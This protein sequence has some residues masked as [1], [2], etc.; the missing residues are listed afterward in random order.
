MIFSFINM[1]L[2]TEST[3]VV[4]SQPKLLK[5]CLIEFQKNNKILQQ[6]CRCFSSTGHNQ[7]DFLKTKSMILMTGHHMA[8]LRKHASNVFQTV[9]ELKSE[10]TLQFAK[11]DGSTLSKFK[12]F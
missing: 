2:S 8:P 10:E 5:E 7:T 4:E 6:I 3:N 12:T 11:S 1:N 9:K